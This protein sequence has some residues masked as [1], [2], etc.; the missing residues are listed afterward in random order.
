MTRGPPF[1]SGFPSNSGLQASPLS[2]PFSLSISQCGEGLSISSI[3]TPPLY[4]HPSPFYIFPNPLLLARLFRQYCPN[5]I[6]DKHK[7]KL[8]WQSYF[9]IF[10]R[11]K[12]NVKRSFINNTFISNT[13]L[14]F[15]PK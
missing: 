13:R 3:D 15:N 10:R 14:R 4:G 1:K 12:N 5:E 8:M 9:F 11:L 7:N 6:P 2:P